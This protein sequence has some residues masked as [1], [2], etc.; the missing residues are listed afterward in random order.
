M[1]EYVAIQ[2]LDFF[3]TLSGLQGR[4]PTP[5]L[6][7]TS[8][9][10]HSGSLHS[11]LYLEQ[12]HLII[13]GTR[14]LE[15]KLT[16]VAALSTWP[17]PPSWR[18]SQQAE[19]ASLSCCYLPHSAPALFTIGIGYMQCTPKPRLFTVSSSILK[20]HVATSYIVHLHFNLCK[21][22]HRFSLSFTIVI[23]YIQCTHK[24]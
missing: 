5:S 4:M 15:R 20:H 24:K 14:I 2:R 1:E 9:T 18:D 3:L 13:Q 22:F 10:S 19:V 12:T 11:R 6:A 17:T 16:A 8:R 23:G 7:A 21:Y